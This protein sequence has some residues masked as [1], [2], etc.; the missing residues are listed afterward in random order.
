MPFQRQ[1]ARLVRVVDLVSGEWVKKEGMEPSYVVTPRKEQISRARIAGTVVTKFVSEDGNF[2]SLTIDDSTATIQAKQWNETA[3][4]SGVEVGESVSM[5]GK[6][7]EYE[8]DIYLVPEIIRSLT[9]DEESMLRLEILARL[10]K[11]TGKGGED[12]KDGE[13]AEESKDEDLRKKVLSIIEESKEGISYGELMKK[14]GAPE[15]RIEDVI[16]ELLGEGICYEPTP[17]KIKK[18]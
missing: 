1:T 14:A 12:A 15:E 16:N 7:R 11:G 9:P 3:L 5:I 4:I 17:G 2:A 18:I 6:V 10:K 8:G 13:K